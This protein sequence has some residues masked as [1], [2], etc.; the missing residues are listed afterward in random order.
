MTFKK[1]DAHEAMGVGTVIRFQVASR[2]H[3][4]DNARYNAVKA[5]NGSWRC[6]GLDQGAYVADDGG[7][8]SLELTANFREGTWIAEGVTKMP[9]SGPTM[10]VEELAATHKE[11]TTKKNSS[12]AGRAQALNKLGVTI[13]LRKDG[14]SIFESDWCRLEV[15]PEVEEFSDVLTRAEKAF[16]NS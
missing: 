2:A 6:F 14:W 3:E 1:R 15:S 16:G 4:G 9:A 13:T 12:F 5:K 10:T 11:A 7:F 8:N